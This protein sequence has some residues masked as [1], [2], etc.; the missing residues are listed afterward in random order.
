M[1]FLKLGSTGSQATL[2]YTRE[3]FTILRGLLLVPMLV[4]EYGANLYGEWLATSGA[5]IYL[6]I[7]DF[8]FARYST[9]HLAKAWGRR[10]PSDISRW[11]GSG[12]LGSLALSGIMG[13]GAIVLISMGAFKEL[14]VGNSV[15]KIALWLTVATVCQNIM[16]EFLRS[17][18]FAV[19]KA[20]SLVLPTIVIRLLSVAIIL[21]ALSKDWPIFLLSVSLWM[22]SF[23]LLCLYILK[24]KYL[25][26][27][28]TWDR[29]GSFLEVLRSSPSAAL[30]SVLRFLTQSSPSI[31]LS[32]VAGGIVVTEFQV[33]RTIVLGVLRVVRIVLTS[34][35]MEIINSNSDRL[36]RR[37]FIFSVVMGAISLLLVFLLRDYLLAFFIGD[38]FFLTSTII[39]LILMMYFVDFCID[40]V[41]EVMQSNL[42][43]TSSNYMSATRSFLQVAFWLLF[44]FKVISFLSLMIFLI[45]SAIFGSFIFHKV[46]YVRK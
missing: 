21:V 1:P 5:L 31:V 27:N 30:S 42:V 3:A 16:N 39:S 15:L 12:A 36:R 34:S 17:A 9:L 26:S 10:N 11:F 19:R 35:T 2:A 22:E 8:G 25:W 44:Y 20:S 29:N 7:V 14:T 32:H 28:I 33:I 40:N 45:V 23:L 38:V 43:I 13:L 24:T 4:N 6:S 41:V 46:S 18:L 37:N